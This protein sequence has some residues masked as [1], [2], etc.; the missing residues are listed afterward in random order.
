MSYLRY[1]CVCLRMW[2][3]SHIVLCF[4]FDFLCLVYPMLPDYVDGLF[5]MV[6]SVFSSVYLQL[7]L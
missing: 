1:V 6:S 2:C 4:W 3:L 7:L 5:V